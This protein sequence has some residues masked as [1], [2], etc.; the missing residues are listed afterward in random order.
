MNE[1]SLVFEL[2]YSNVL[3][4]TANIVCGKTKYKVNLSVPRLFLHKDILC[5]PE[6]FFKGKYK[7]KK[8]CAVKPIKL[9]FIVLTLTHVHIPISVDFSPQSPDNV[10]GLVGSNGSTSGFGRVE[11]TSPLCLQKLGK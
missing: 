11:G 3:A 7:K 6:C 1:C 2:T 10:L 4:V 5:H 8:K 9:L